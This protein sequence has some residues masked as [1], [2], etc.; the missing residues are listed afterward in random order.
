MTK[1]IS[2]GIPF[3]FVLAV[4]CG[5]GRNASSDTLNRDVDLVAGKSSGTITLNDNPA[6]TSGGGSRSTGGSNTARP[7]AARTG[8]VASG[9]TIALSSQSRVCTN[10]HKVGDTFNALV[11]EDIMGS[12]GVLI[13]AGS[14]AQVQITSL[15]GKSNVRDRV[16]MGFVVQSVQVGSKTYALDSRITAIQTTQE[17]SAQNKDAQKVI[18]GAVA[19]AI[20]GQILGKDTKSTVIGAATGAAAGTVVAMATGDYDGCV[21]KDGSITIALNA[22]VVVTITQ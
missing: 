16:E 10:T 19:G 11:K 4:A 3:L 2:R 22:P 14:P 18:G 12:N 7:P 13:P 21:P 17:R 15:S 1:M 5:D 9:T 20:I 8:T 6:K